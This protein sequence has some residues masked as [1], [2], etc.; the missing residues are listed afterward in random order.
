MDFCV[1]S[2]FRKL[3]KFQTNYF[4]NLSYNENYWDKPELKSAFMKYLVDIFGLDLSLW[5]DLG[6]WDNRYRP[7][8]YFDGDLL[9]SNVCIYSMDMIVLGKRCKVAQISAVGTLPEYRR[10]G[11]SSKLTLKA[12]DWAKENHEFF[13]L[14]ADK[15]AYPFY[16]NCGFRH[17]DE[18]KSRIRTTGDEAHPGAVKMDIQSKDQLDQIY[19]FASDR[20]PV[21]DVLGVSNRKLFMFWCLYFAAD[22]IYHIP[23]LDI[24]VLYK[25]ANGV[26]T[27]LDIV[28]G[29]IPDF[30]EIYPYICDGSDE[31]IDFLFMTDKL[32]LD[33]IDT[34][35][36]EDNGTH[37][38]GKIPLETTKFIFPITSQA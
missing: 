28:G 14:F 29:Q 19:R 10:K 35:K 31:F 37:L 9:V 38:L 32:K 22:N 20:A 15:E 30:S 33:S 21:S 12:M 8:S 1:E 34:I 36:V 6:F 4:M 5:D 13:Y 3:K 16:K 24:L 23:E 26:V 2:C 7:F 17:I 11:L 18:Y 25:R 27:I